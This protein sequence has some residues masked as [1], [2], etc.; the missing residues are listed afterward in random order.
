MTPAPHILLIRLEALLQSWGNRSPYNDR[1]TLTRPTKSGVIGLLAAADGHDRDEIREDADD[2]LPLSDLAD[3]RFGVRADRPGRLTSD[4][5][6]SG[7]GTYPLRPRDII[8]DPARAD[9]AAAALAEDH[10]PAFGHLRGPG[11]TDWYSAPKNIA[12]HPD[13]HTLIAT[14]SKRYPQVSRRWYLADAAFLAA[15]E[16]TDKALLRRLA[17]RLHTPRRLLWLGRK[18]CAPTQPLAHGIRPGTLEDVLATT[19]LLPRSRPAPTAAWVEVDPGTAGS[20]TINDQ[21][22]SFAN[23]TRTRA[24]RWEQRLSLT[25]PQENR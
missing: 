25:P 15:V 12:P 2:F 1:D 18:H 14:N 3:L 6:T 21:P 24:M 5:Q 22:V 16:S 23:H 8:T 20:S 17:D 10:G 9:R 11:L 7:G 13:T 19:P 4:F